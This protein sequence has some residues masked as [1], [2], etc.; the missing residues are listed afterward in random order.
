MCNPFK[1]TVDVLSSK[2][3]ISWIPLITEHN[4]EQFSARV[5]LR[6][7]CR[8][9]I[10]EKMEINET[11][12]EKIRRTETSQNMERLSSI[13]HKLGY[14]CSIINIP[15]WYEN[16]IVF[17]ILRI[18]SRRGNSNQ[19]KSY[20]FSISTFILYL[21]RVFLKK[22]DPVFCQE[23]YPGLVQETRIIRNFIFSSKIGDQIW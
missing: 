13:S 23:T 8:S 20:H 12:I 16:W 4:D 7:A 10:G 17:S 5:N 1:I 18:S 21:C 3:N 11:E 19:R 15:V 9:K 2:C 6:M 22:F 14:T